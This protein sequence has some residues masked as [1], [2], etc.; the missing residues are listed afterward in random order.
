MTDVGGGIVITAEPADAV[1]VT[2]DTEL[3]VIEVPE[4]GPVGPQGPQGTPGTDG[5]TIWYGTADPLPSVGQEGDFYIN[6]NTH[7]LFGPKQ[8]GAWPV[9]VSIVGPQ[10]PRG[11]S[12]LY[13]AGA[14][15]GAIGIDGDFYINTSTN[16]IYGPRAAGVWPTGISL[17]GPQGIQGIQGVR[18]SLFYTGAG[19]PG[20]ITG[21]LNGDNYLNTTNGDV[22]TLVGGVWTLEGN[23]RG[24]QGIQGLPGAGSPGVALPLVNA[25][26]AV[27]GVS[28]NFSRED[29]VHPLYVL[30]NYLSGLGISVSG[31]TLT[32]Q[33]GVA[34]DSTNAAFMI[35][36]AAMSKTT[37]A[38]AAGTGNGGLDTG[39]IAASTWYHIHLIEKLG[40]PIAVDITF[41]LSAT[42]PT[43]QS[44][45]TLA[46]RIATLYINA[47][48]VWR[49]VTN[50]YDHFGWVAPVGDISVNSGS[51][52]TILRTLV[53]MPAGISVLGFLNIYMQD[54]EAGVTTQAYGNV[55][56]TDSAAS[57]S[58]TGTYVSIQG[59]TAATAAGGAHILLKINNQQFYSA[60]VSAAAGVLFRA[61]GIGWLDFRGR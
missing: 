15:T 28:T 41:S 5:N 35:L 42:A 13:G 27:V 44:G 17:V 39:A 47:S 26:T 6:T 45:W 7:F 58:N 54:S 33:P 3:E 53:S 49:P 43:L 30:R 40:P 46:R 24:P 61:D 12:V 23:I 31:N 11:N 18:G 19:A 8:A 22:Y 56:A 55:C 29:H 1:I 20:T 32:M 37:A 60:N 59:A 38:W 9:G 2:A 57:N 51:A 50:L 16:F 4:Q 14:P 25:P 34:A 10:G 52:A 48:S 36:A 21:Q